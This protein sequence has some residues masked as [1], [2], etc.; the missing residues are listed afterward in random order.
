MFLCSDG[1]LLSMQQ[2][3]KEVRAALAAEGLFSVTRDAALG[4]EPQPHLSEL[5]WRSPR[6]RHWRGGRAKFASAT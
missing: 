6:S 2:L 5:G 3:V 4:L 1:M